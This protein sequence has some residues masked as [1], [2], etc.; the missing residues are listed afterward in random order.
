MKRDYEIYIY[1]AQGVS[2]LV[3]HSIHFNDVAAIR[4][5]K[6]FAGDRPFEVWC[7]FEHAD[8]NRSLASTLVFRSFA[9]AR[10]PMSPRSNSIVGKDEAL[11]ANK[12]EIRLCSPAHKPLLFAGAFVTEDQ[13]SEFARNLLH[14]HKEMLYAEVWRGMKLLR[15]V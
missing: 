8:L 7:D 10:T 3:M 15:Q 4:R 13:A 1:G 9:P 6:T 2:T 11:R 12:Y 14:R 5:A